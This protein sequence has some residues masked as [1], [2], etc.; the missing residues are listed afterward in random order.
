[1][2][3]PFPKQL[4]AHRSQITGVRLAPSPD[5]PQ[6]PSQAS[7]TLTRT[8]TSTHQPIPSAANP[9]TRPRCPPTAVLAPQRPVRRDL[10][11]RLG[12]RSLPGKR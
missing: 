6:S 3:D 10:A 5:P 1:M 11:G 2:L 9:P 4:G 7:Q 8:N 12:A